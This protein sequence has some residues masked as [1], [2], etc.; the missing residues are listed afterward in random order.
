MHTG[1]KSGGGGV[2]EV[3]AKI[4]SGVKGVSGKIA[5]GG[6]P[7]INKFFENLPVSYPTLPPMRHYVFLY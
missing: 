1:W 4:P 3:F 7:I 2:L 5:K 6:P